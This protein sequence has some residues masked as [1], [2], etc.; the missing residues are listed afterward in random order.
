MPDLFADLDRVE[1]AYRR[2]W[3]SDSTATAES[4]LAE[5][6]SEGLGEEWTVRDRPF[7]EVL[8]ASWRSGD[9]PEEALEVMRFALRARRHTS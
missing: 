4:L 6:G 8:L 5:L 1:T 3:S 2:A 9:S 7:C